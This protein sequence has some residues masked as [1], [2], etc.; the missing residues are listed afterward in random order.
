M[1]RAER[2]RVAR[3]DSKK[4]ATYNLTEFQI[5]ERIADELEK[6]RKSGYEEGMNRAMVL[7][8]AIPLEVL[9]N[10]YWQDS[11]EQ[12]Q[13]FTNHMLEYI[14]MVNTGEL[15]LNELREHLW[16]YGGVRFQEGE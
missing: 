12:L 6:A 8:L 14:E 7:T 13:E 1:S 11:C 3:E 4:K 15:D 2:R 10:F 5:Q 16:E 9:M